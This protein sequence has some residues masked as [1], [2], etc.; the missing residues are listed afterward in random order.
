MTLSAVHTQ[1]TPEIKIEGRQST[2]LRSLH[3]LSQNRGLGRKQTAVTTA[4]G[5]FYRKVESLQR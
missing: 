1:T 3:A 4:T 5:G 2:T